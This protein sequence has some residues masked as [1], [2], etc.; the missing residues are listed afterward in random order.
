[1][2]ADDKTKKCA[3]PSCH[4]AIPDGE[5]Y[6]STYCEGKGETADITCSC[7]HAGCRH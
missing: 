4:C 5:T 3:H 7:N 2:N 6:C 1:M